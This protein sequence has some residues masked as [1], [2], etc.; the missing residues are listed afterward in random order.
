MRRDI[1]LNVSRRWL[2]VQEVMGAAIVTGTDKVASGFGNGDCIM[3]DLRNMVFAVADGTERHP[4]SSRLFLESFMSILGSGNFPGD[5]QEWQEVIREVFSR[6]EYHCK[7]TFSMVALSREKKAYIFNGG[8]SM[9]LVANRENGSL[10]FSSDVN[11]NFA[12]R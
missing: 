10:Q 5:R 3:I 6:Q 11:M 1:M 2:M 12:G 9:V 8:D 4:R 7:T